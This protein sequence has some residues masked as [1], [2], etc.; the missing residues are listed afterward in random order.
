MEKYKVTLTKEERNELMEIINKGSH[1][2][3][4]FRSAYIHLNCDEGEFADKVTNAQ[5]SK[6]LKIGM[7]TIDRTK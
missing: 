2:S 3:H 5:I 4:K 1:S 6:V 7:R